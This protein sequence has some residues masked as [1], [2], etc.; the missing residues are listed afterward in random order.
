MFLKQ[1]NLNRIVFKAEPN[2]EL[3]KYLEKVTRK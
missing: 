1:D 3:V 2:F